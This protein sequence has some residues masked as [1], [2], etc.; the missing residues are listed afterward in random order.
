MKKRVLVVLLTVVL[1]LPFIKVNAGYMDSYIDWTLDRTVFAHKI[2]NGEEHT[3]N[4]AMITA[5]GK[6][7]YCIE[8]GVDADKASYYSSTTNI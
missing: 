8:P 7:A 5:N 6:V 4:L 3:N 2:Q 1:L